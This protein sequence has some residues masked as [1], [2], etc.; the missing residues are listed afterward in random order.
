MRVSW[1]GRDFGATLMNESVRK[2]L[3]RTCE[4]QTRLHEGYRGCRVI[5]DWVIKP[6]GGGESD[7]RRRVTNER[8]L[9]SVETL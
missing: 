9:M 5:G 3:E 2:A 8:A 6:V 4:S 7:N 1:L